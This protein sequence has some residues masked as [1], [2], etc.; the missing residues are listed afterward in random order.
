MAVAYEALD[1]RTGGTQPPVDGDIVLDGHVLRLDEV[2]AVARS[3][4]PPGLALAPAARDRAGRS[5]ALR[6]ALTAE[7]LPIYGV[8]TGFGDSAGRQVAPVKTAELQRHL[9]RYHLNGVGGHAPAEVVRATMLVR[10]NCLARGYSGVRAEVIDLL[11]RLLAEDILP[12]VP[13]RGSLGASG[14]LIPLCYLAAALVGEGEVMHRG[15]RKP[16][17]QALRDVG[18][19]PLEL[20]AKEGLA[21][22]NGTSFM[23]GFA[24]LAVLDAAELAFVADLCT[25][26]ACE[27]LY[28][29]RG[30]FAPFLQAQKPHPGQVASARSIARLLEGSRLATDPQHLGKEGSGGPAFGD[31]TFRR[32]ERPVQERYSVRCA[33]HVVGVLLDTLEW[34]RT[35]IATEINSSND[36]PLFDPDDGQVHSGGNFYGGH[37]AQAMDTLKVAV[38]SVADMLDRQLELIVD[39]K[40]N[41][42]LTPNLIPPWDDG[43]HRAGLHHGYKGMQINCS[44]LTAEALKLTMP[45]TVFS[46][47]TEAHNQDKVSL[48]T[49]AARDAR[50]VIELAEYVAAIHLHALCQALDLRGRELAGAGTRRAYEAV[51]RVA[52]FVSEDRPLDSEVRAVAHLIRSGA[53]RAAATGTTTDPEEGSAG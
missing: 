49:I 11:L 52:S 18:L 21:L 15:E 26:M 51:R 3:A 43:D 33:P 14:D 41:N 13:E 47:S 31:A 7:G 40:F 20:E 6:Q 36:N 5:R 24:A 46:R 45:A 38:A 39:E 4:R 37:V 19:E 16:S 10:A 42:G 34:A 35:W 44:A 27:A 12:V 28:G 9:I 29:N 50:A 23:A 17:A 25:A 8:S 2:A 22:I 1:A 48:G 32:L 53:L 30:H